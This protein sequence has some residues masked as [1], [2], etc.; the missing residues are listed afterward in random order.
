MSE[1]TELPWSLLCDEARGRPRCLIV[2]AKGNEIAS[3]NPYRESW[4]EYADLMKAAPELLEVVEELA[5]P[6]LFPVSKIENL[7]RKARAAIK[8][9]RGE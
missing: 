9:A 1:H 5:T 2:D 7:I 4:N 8:K 6:G 3:V